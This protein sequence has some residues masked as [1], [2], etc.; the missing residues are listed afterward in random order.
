MSAITVLL[1][2][3]ESGV[4]R[5]VRRLLESEGDVLVVAEAA[6]GGQAVRAAARWRPT[7]AIVDLTMPG[8]PG[9]AAIRQ[10]RAVSPD[11]AILGFT[12]F[13]SDTYVYE[14]MRAGAHGYLLKSA[15]EAELVGAVRAVSGGRAFL[16]VAMRTVVIRRASLDARRV[17]VALRMMRELV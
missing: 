10:L 11:T 2:D 6:D 8:L 9:L 12:M 13:R 5:A 14:A 16:P 3:D 1:V 15:H 4:R 17:D 7:V